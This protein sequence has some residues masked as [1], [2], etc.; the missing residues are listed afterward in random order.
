MTKSN[1][2]SL[3]LR[4]FP[5]DRNQKLFF[6][7]DESDVSYAD[8]EI[9]IDQFVDAFI[10]HGIAPG[11]R[12]AVQLEKS[13]N[14]VSL[15]LACLKYGAIYI[16]LNTAYGDA[17][18]NYLINDAQPTLL[19]T[20]PNRKPAVPNEAEL[21]TKILSLGKNGEGT[22]LKGLSKTSNSNKI[23]CAKENDIAAILYT[24][25][26]TG[27]PKGAMLSHGNLASNGK[28]LIRLWQLEATDILLHAL[29][30]YHVHGL[31]VAMHCALMSGARIFFME[32]FDA[33]DV[34]E[35]LPHCSVMM[36]VPTYYSRMLANPTFDEQSCHKMR[37]F[38]C[39]SAPLS[40][41]LWQAFAARAGHKILERYGMSEAGIITS[42][43]Y[44]GERLEGTVGFA[45]KGVTLRIVNKHGNECSVEE[46]G[47]LQVKGP[48]VFAGYWKKE[49]DN[50]TYFTKDLFFKTG[51]LATQSVDGRIAIVGRIK[52]L[53]ISGGL[54][55]YP[56]EVELVIDSIEGVSESAVIGLP[57]PDFGESV[58]A[59]ITRKGHANVTK[60]EIL[61]T[62]GQ[63]LANYKRPKVIHFME[64]L[65]RNT[66]GK[67][68]KNLLRDMLG[69][70][71][72]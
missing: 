55:V 23:F 49:K 44:D 1:V 69:K 30:L 14:T 51:D 32:K 47:E 21:H 66:M 17:E 53:I 57:D 54:N 6:T 34:I 9:E 52:D 42:N 65:T 7:G 18:L 63:R 71:R 4:S 38:V 29:P 58:A 59:A 68:Q 46:V 36:G 37:L 15:Y 40:A 24:S 20:N 35:H 5:E 60:A 50:P 8:F 3:L 67:I 64:E 70:I 45:L 25:G 31:F 12:V 16:P 72:N 28:T 61:K 11:D 56:K 26:T 41:Q 39:G 33:Q 43:P 62:L 13:I 22:L 19:V 2:Y 10:K 27:H 48:N